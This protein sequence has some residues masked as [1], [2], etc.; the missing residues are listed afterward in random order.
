M[1]GYQKCVGSIVSWVQI[2]LRIENYFL[3]QNIQILFLDIEEVMNQMF[4]IFMVYKKK[5]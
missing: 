3:N 5:C 1:L 4:K 2:Y